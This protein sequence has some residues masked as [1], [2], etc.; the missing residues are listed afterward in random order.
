MSIEAITAIE[1]FI[2][3]REQG[4]TIAEIKQRI[5]DF[6]EWREERQLLGYNSTHLKPRR[7]YG[8]QIYQREG[9]TLIP[10]KV[11]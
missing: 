9:R 6:V 2:H 11:Q 8:N 4:V 3:N 10:E 1:M 7:F 5:A